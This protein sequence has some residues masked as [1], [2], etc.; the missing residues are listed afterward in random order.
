MD[1]RSCE[2]KAIT[3]NKMCDCCAV[4]IDDYNGL[5]INN[6]IKNRNK[7]KTNENE[8]RKLSK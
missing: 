5:Q 8:S 1:A 7:W 4:S 2:Q 6:R 3:E